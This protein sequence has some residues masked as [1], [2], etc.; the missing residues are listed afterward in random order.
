VAWCR[1]RSQCVRLITSLVPSASA[2]DADYHLAADSGSIYEPHPTLTYEWDPDKASHSQFYRGH[3]PAARSFD[4]GPHPADPHS[5][6]LQNTALAGKPSNGK[7]P[8][9]L[10]GQSEQVPG[11]EIWVYGGHGGC[12]YILH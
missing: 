4:L 9:G 2:T 6:I 3:R 10:N 11:Q 1:S 5:T 12:A 7:A 8:M